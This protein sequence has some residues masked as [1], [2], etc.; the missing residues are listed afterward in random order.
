[1]KRSNETTS[2]SKSAPNRAVLIEEECNEEPRTRRLRCDNAPLPSSS[3]QR[4]LKVLIE[5]AETIVAAESSN[6][7]PTSSFHLLEDEDRSLST[8]ERGGQGK[9]N[10]EPRPRPT[11][12]LNHVQYCKRE[13][14]DSKRSRYNLSVQRYSPVGRPLVAP[15][16]LLSG[17]RP[18]EIRMQ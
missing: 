4:E 11:L 13:G 6:D 1:M 2:S 10:T 15:P 8:N 5:A 7:S 17:L 16:P 3:S 18:G 12:L 14:N 9:T